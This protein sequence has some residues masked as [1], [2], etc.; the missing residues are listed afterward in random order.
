MIHTKRTVFTASHNSLK[1][2]AYYVEN[3]ALN[4]VETKDYPFDILERVGGGD[5]FAGGTIFGL[6]Q[7]YNNPKGA[8]DI[9]VAC[10][11]LK[12]SEYGDAFTQSL[13]DVNNFLSNKSKDIKR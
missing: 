9:G 5:A 12:H 3:N 1:A 2:F 13:T 8:I 10:D 6:L 4:C 7:N 11:V